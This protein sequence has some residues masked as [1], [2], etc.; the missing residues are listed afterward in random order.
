MSRRCVLY[1]RLYAVADV[2]HVASANAARWMTDSHTFL[3]C[4]RFACETQFIEHAAFGPVVLWCVTGLILLLYCTPFVAER[5]RPMPKAF[6]FTSFICGCGLFQALVLEPQDTVD[7]AMYRAEGTLQE[8]RILED[9]EPVDAI[10]AWAKEA[11]KE[12]HP[13][14]REPVHTGVL[15]ET[16]REVHC[17]RRRAW[18][19]LDVGVMSFF[20]QRYNITLRNP[21]VDPLLKDQCPRLFYQDNVEFEEWYKIENT[22]ISVN[23]CHQ[24]TAQQ[25]CRRFFPPPH[26]CVH[27]LT[28]HVAKE[29]AK[30]D[31]K[32]LD[33]K[34]VYTKLEL[35]MD[36]TVQEIH[37]R[38]IDIARNQHRLNMSPYARIDNGT[39]PNN[40]LWDIHSSSAHSVI[41][42][43]H[44]LVDAEKREFTDKPCTPMFNGAL[45]AKK[46]KEGNLIIEA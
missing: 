29:Q 18:E 37:E 44:K 22:T 27:D 25:T 19:G 41:D 17:N 31:S 43:Y 20:G 35:E 21:R 10:M 23:E 33:S 6:F 24:T 8:L 26:N 9:E 4:H 28:V 30:F 34:S 15:E 16:C 32:R 11:A 12:H 1:D 36:A 2:F 13:I 3:N 38:F 42:A 45:C 14:V 40:D 46:D 7:A 39:H 5:V